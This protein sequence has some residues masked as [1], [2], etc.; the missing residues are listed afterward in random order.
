MNNSVTMIQSR[1]T[2]HFISTGAASPYLE[3]RL[4]DLSQ[5]LPRLMGQTR[6]SLGE[7]FPRTLTRSPISLGPQPLLLMQQGL[8]PYC[9]IL[10]LL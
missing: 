3:R 7:T 8:R 4:P 9:L 5:T 10:I 2:C 6:L 1:E